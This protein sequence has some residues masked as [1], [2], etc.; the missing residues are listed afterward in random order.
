[1]SWDP[2]LDEEHGV[3][4]NRLGITSPEKLAAAEADITHFRIA[5]LHRH[6]LPGR[7][8]LA[9]LQ[10]IHKW[11]FGD[12]YDWAGAI[13]TVSIGKGALFCLPKHIVPVADDLFE[14]LD[15][16]H[17]LRGLGHD[18][19][20]AKLTELFA[21]VNALH[22]FRE[23]NGR[24]MRAFLTQL[25]RDASYRIRWTAM[26]REANV[27]A[28]WAAHRGDNTLLHGMLNELVEGTGGPRGDPA[29]RPREPR[30]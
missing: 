18:E 27:A 3:L 24:S 21:D 19:F 10:A 14:R 4:R 7:Y 16:D 11:I 23:G 20:V 15:G 29:P 22:P 2:Y 26:D 13:R 25:A 1:V 5:Q 6:P 30:D 17:Y 12:I 8:D 28:S 9:H